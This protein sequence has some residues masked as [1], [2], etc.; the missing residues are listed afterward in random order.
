[1]Q[2]VLNHFGTLFNPFGEEVYQLR[3]SMIK[4]I[5]IGVGALA[6]GIGITWSTYSAASKQGGTY[7]VAY[8]LIFVGIS[9]TF[10]GIVLLVKSF[11]YPSP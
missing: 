8:G 2:S 10:R 7:I 3:K 1:M 5:I 6:L 11:A 9:Y 4:P